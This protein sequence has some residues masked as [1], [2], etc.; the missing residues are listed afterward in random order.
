MLHTIERRQFLRGNFRTQP[1]SLLPPWSG[2]RAG[3]FDL[4]TRCGA[5]LSACPNGIL[6]AGDGGYPEVDFRRSE[7]SFCGDCLRAC[8]PRAL[9]TRAATPWHL[10]P[11]VHDTCLAWRGIDCRRCSEMCAAGALRIS[12]DA[13]GTALPVIDTASCSGCGAC[14]A[15]C[16]VAAIRLCEVS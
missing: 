11:V 1:V 6:V 2:P 5:C 15:P 3:F 7:C 13:A 9:S 10:V 4:C 8:Q 14:V 12:L 16:P